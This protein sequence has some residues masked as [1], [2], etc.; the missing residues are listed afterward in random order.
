MSLDVFQIAF[1]FIHK[2]NIS[3]VISFHISTNIYTLLFDTYL[4][5]LLLLF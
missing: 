4:R 3:N 1:K 2:I 5:L